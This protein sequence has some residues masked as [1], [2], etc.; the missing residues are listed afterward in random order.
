MKWFDY[1][2]II[3][4]FVKAIG[5]TKV[6]EWKMAMHFVKGHVIAL[7]EQKYRCCLS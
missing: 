5:D 6:A 4:N 3:Y 7:E 1:H 2:N